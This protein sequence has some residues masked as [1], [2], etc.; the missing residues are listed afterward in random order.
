MKRAS[1]TKF[2]GVPLEEYLPWKEHLK[3]TENK[4]AKRIGLMYKAKPFLDKDSVLSVYFSYIH[5]YIIY[6][7]LAWAI[8]HRTTLKKISSQQ[9]YPLRIVYNKDRYYHMKDLFRSCNVL[10]VYK[11]DLLNNSIF[12]HKLKTGTG[13]AAFHTTFR[14][15]FH[16]YA[17]RF[18]SLNYSKPNI[19]LRKSR[20]G[21]SMQDPAIWNNFVANTEKQT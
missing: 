13:S 17:T 16:S 6:A 4:I 11:L 3:Y 21:I 18:S 8:T 5:S 14:M 10:N 12:M 19:R 15:P 9:K 20:F 1:Y 7:N 2:F